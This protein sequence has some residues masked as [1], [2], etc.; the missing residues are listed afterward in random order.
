MNKRKSTRGKKPAKRRTPIDYVLIF[1]KLVLLVLTMIYPVFFDIG[2]GLS[3][4]FNSAPENRKYGMMMAV[5]GFIIAYSV[6]LCLKKYNIASAV[7]GIG[8][9]IVCIYAVSCYAG[10]ADSLGLT[11]YNLVPLSQKY[12]SYNYPTIAVTI[13]QTI[14]AGIQYFSLDESEKRDERRRKK[15][16]EKNAEAPKIVDDDDAE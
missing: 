15:E 1:V 2:G 11:D 13:L 4:Y 14:L 12:R 8:A 7:L 10:V 9:S 16:A 5:S 6:V 3:A